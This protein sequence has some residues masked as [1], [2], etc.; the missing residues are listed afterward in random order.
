MKITLTSINDLSE[1][2]HH[3]NII[4]IGKVSELSKEDIEEIFSPCLPVTIKGDRF[5][6]RSSND[7]FKSISKELGS[8][9]GVITMVKL[10]G[11]SIDDIKSRNT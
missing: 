1:N 10:K 2:I 7:M 8:E 5:G 3:S 6:Y 9:Y 4:R 11:E